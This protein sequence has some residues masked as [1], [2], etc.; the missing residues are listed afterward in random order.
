[1]AVLG[2]PRAPIWR[3]NLD[4]GADD[5]PSGQD[6]AR[7]PWV[8]FAPLTQI[9]RKPLP[10]DMTSQ[11]CSVVVLFRSSQALNYMMGGDGDM[12]FSARCHRDRVSS[13]S[14]W[15]RLGWHLAAM[16]IDAVCG[17]LRGECEHC[18]TAWD[19]HAARVQAP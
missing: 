6:M 14:V 18:A 17:A 7:Q 4:A 8:P 1:M 3:L 2:T 5:A 12:T 19:N 9:Y 13:R 16:T 11:E 10:Q 15:A